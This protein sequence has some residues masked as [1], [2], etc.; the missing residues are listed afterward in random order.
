MGNQERKVRGYEMHVE[1]A[2]K[3]KAYAIEQGFLQ[4]ETVYQLPAGKVP[5]K[6]V[7]VTDTPVKFLLLIQ[8][9]G[10]GSRRPIDAN[11]FL[12][13][14]SAPTKKRTPGGRH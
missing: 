8:D 1:G 6:I 10:D 11:P 4:G 14:K 2:A 12:L 9:Q 5:Y 13:T 3:R 7:G